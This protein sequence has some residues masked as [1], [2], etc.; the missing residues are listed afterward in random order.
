[1]EF[2]FKIS[3]WTSPLFPIP[4]PTT[5]LT[6]WHIFNLIQ[7]GLSIKI[8]CPIT[9]YFLLGR[10]YNPIRNFPF[11]GIPVARN[12]QHNPVIRHILFLNQH[13]QRDYSLLPTN[14]SYYCEIF[15]ACATWETPIKLMVNLMRI[16]KQIPLRVI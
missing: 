2:N 8:V 1:M 5:A 11:F 9:P 7:K 3:Q 13:H 12:S 10:F 6:I 14:S 4:I 15:E 16:N